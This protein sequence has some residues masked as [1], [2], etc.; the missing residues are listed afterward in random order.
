[1]KKGLSLVLV[2]LLVFGLSVS[3]FSGNGVAVSAQGTWSPTTEAADKTIVVAKTAALLENLLSMNF[4]ANLQIS[5]F[6]SALDNDETFLAALADDSGFVALSAKGDTYAFS[7]KLS[8]E[9]LIAFYTAMDSTPPV[10]GNFL[11]KVL[12]VLFRVLYGSRFK[13]IVTSDVVT[14][15]LL[16]RGKYV[17]LP[18]DFV[19][20]L[21]PTVDPA[22]IVP[23]PSIGA[24]LIAE[25]DVIGAYSLTKDGK[26][27]DVA[28]L[29][30]TRFPDGADGEYAFLYFD[31]NDLVRIEEFA[32]D[33]TFTSALVLLVSSPASN[34]DFSVSPAKESKFFKWLLDR[35]Q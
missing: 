9:A 2:L 10:I 25:S 33:G 19:S 26:T 32:A 29:D 4:T 21:L 24:D 18:R 28:K 15:V 13:L 12:G 22:G 6:L 3:A 31:G 5:D 27:Y 11:A 7:A 14:A 1:M 20:P 17:T 23:F 8:W 16:D 34:S 35:I 30:L